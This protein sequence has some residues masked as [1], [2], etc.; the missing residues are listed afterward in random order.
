VVV[1]A[2]T[3]DG[4]QTISIRPTE[5]NASLRAHGEVH[6]VDVA[7]R[8]IDLVDFVALHAQ[9]I[10]DLAVRRGIGD[11]GR[12][13]EVTEERNIRQARQEIGYEAGYGGFP[14]PRV[15]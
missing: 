8:A 10:D 13:A 4:G 3:V 9:V 7:K 11:G 14:I 6:P 5:N 1:G 2:E 12:A 15:M